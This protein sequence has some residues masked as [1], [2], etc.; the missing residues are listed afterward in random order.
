MQN[1]CKSIKSEFGKVADY[2]KGFSIGKKDLMKAVDRSSTVLSLFEVQDKT[3]FLTGYLNS[4]GR[5]IK[6]I[7]SDLLK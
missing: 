4:Q 6:S 3:A 1:S 2:G 7:N 5:S